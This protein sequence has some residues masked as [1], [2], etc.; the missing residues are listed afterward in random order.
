MKLPVFCISEGKN[1]NYV[2][3]SFLSLLVAR[4]YLVCFSLDIASKGDTE[5]YFTV[6]PVVMV[7][8]LNY[9]IL[10]YTAPSLNFM[11]VTGENY[12][13]ICINVTGEPCLILFSTFCQKFSELHNHIHINSEFHVADLLPISI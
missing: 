7:F 8:Y 2:S 12:I 4:N 11:K 6:Y 9:V 3:L 13:L 5:Y 10:H 1:V